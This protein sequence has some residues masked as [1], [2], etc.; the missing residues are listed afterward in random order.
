MARAE[1][2]FA[3]DPKLWG[4]GVFMKSMALYLDFL[5][6]EWGVKTLMGKTLEDNGR[7]VGAMRKLGAVVI[8]RSDRNGA[9]EF[10]WT[11]ER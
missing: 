3:L 9:P 1:I 8:E 11:I 6:G 4:S 10:I 2:G 7:G 5:F